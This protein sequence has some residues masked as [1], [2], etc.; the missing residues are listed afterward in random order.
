MTDEAEEDMAEKQAKQHDIFV[1]TYDLREMMYTDQ[2]GKFP[3][4]SSRGN[5]YQMVLHELNI[6][7]SWV[8]PK[9]NH[10][11]GKMILA[12]SRALARIKLC[13][14]VLRHQVLNNK[15]YVAYKEAT[16]LSGMTYQLD[17]PNVIYLSFAKLV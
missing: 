12:R 14:I 9:K 3:Y 11:E 10:S 8:E 4:I 15:A 17:P 1:V 5:K 2:T 7:S 6:N 13:G 16:A